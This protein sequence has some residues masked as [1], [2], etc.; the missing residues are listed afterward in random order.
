[1]VLVGFCGGGGGREG[2]QEGG[3]EGLILVAIPGNSA[4][5]AVESQQYLEPCS[6]THSQEQRDSKSLNAY[7]SSIPSPHIDDPELNPGCAF[8]PCVMET[9]SQRY[10]HRST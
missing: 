5:T 3:R 6:V 2:R 1:M 10:D 9:T 8:P 4:F 7:L